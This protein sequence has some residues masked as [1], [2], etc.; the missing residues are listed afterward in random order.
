M[1]N[2]HLCGK[3]VIL[4]KSHLQRTHKWTKKD[5]KEFQ[6]K[7]LSAYKKISKGNSDKQLTTDVSSDVLSTSFLPKARTRSNESF[8]TVAERRKEL[9]WTEMDRFDRYDAFAGKSAIDNK[10]ANS[11]SNIIDSYL[12][13]IVTYLD[14]TYANLHQE[15]SK[16]IIDGRSNDRDIVDGHMDVTMYLHSVLKPSLQLAIDGNVLEMRRLYNQ[17]IGGGFIKV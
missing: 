13:G 2:C 11:V 9:S 4:L 14:E 15:I 1:I 5:A 10:N 17:I 6:E 12:S 3:T 7:A 16:L 8:H